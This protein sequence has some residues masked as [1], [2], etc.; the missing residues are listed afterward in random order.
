MA[1]SAYA[2]IC[3]ERANDEKASAFVETRADKS[4][5]KSSLD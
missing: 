2:F 3:D 4:E 1:E 5:D